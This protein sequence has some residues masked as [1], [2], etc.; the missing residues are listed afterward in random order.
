MNEEKK[1]DE[2]TFEEK[3]ARFERAMD[4]GSEMIIAK[5]SEKMKV[6]F[7]DEDKKEIKSLYEVSF[8]MSS[9]ML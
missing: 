4:F 3:K 7:S 6:Q 9:L 5:L 1:M 2:K 8:A